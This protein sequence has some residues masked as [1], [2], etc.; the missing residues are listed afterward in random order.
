MCQDMK[1]IF[2]ILWKNNPENALYSQGDMV[3]PFYIWVFDFNADRFP[4]I[5]LAIQATRFVTSKY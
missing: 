3:I 2:W 1:Y 4:T 5:L